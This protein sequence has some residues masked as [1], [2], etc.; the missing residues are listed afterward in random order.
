MIKTVIT[1]SLIDKLNS[2]SQDIKIY[3]N[4][5]TYANMTESFERGFMDK[6]DV[7]ELMDI[8]NKIKKI[9]KKYEKNKSN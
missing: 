5:N 4:S 9:S 2:I 1:Q 3:I 7:N 6:E 8:R